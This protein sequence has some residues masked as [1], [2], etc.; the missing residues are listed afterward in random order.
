[1]AS[2]LLGYQ[3]DVASAQYGYEDAQSDYQE[4]LINRLIQLDQAYEDEDY[5]TFS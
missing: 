3:R 4:S 1:M 2:G 5:I